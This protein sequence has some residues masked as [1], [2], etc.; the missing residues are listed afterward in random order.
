LSGGGLYSLVCDDSR[1]SPCSD[2][3]VWLGCGDIGRLMNV[4]EHDDGAFSSGWYG[5]CGEVGCASSDGYLM[6][7]IQKN[8]WCET[9][10]RII[11]FMIRIRHIP[12]A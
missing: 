7:E 8:G 11:I 12:V 10:L 5:G 6:S 2:D 9:S 4:V 3:A 1:P